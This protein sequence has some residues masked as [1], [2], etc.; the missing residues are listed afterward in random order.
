MFS[1]VLALAWPGGALQRPVV[2]SSTPL[3]CATDLVYAIRR[4]RFQGGSHEMCSA[5]LCSSYVPE[6]RTML[7]SVDARVKEAWVIALL[8]LVSRASGRTGIGIA[9]GMSEYRLSTFV[10]K[11]ATSCHALHPSRV[12]L[13]L[14]LRQV[15]LAVDEVHLNTTPGAC[16]CCHV[17][18]QTTSSFWFLQFMRSVTVATAAVQVQAWRC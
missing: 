14:P 15:A 7:H 6:P 5:C 11:C 13:A 17:G 9:A 4:A 1:R 3:L 16:I 2:M 18:M 12:R 8:L 10:R